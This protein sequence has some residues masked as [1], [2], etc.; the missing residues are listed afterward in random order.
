MKRI[1]FLSICLI[2]CIDVI[3]QKEEDIIKNFVTDLFDTSISEETIVKNYLVELKYD[4]N[5]TISLQERND[6]QLLYLKAIRI[7]MLEEESNPS[8]LIPD[9]INANPKN[10]V[11]KYLD[12]SHLDEFRFHERKAKPITE[13]IYVLLDQDKK[14]ILQYF[15][16]E[17]G[18]IKY[19]TLFV[20]SEEASFFGH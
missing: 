13:N 10:V 17:E 14:K 12:Y 16:I 7:Q 3:A 20:K 19:F 8:W 11:A 5:F 18:R 2:S 15:F 6:Q 9:K 1:L 4:E